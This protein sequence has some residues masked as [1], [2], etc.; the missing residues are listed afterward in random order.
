[1]TRDRWYS[2]GPF[3][4]SGGDYKHITALQIACQQ[5]NTE[6]VQF[7]LKSDGNPNIFR[8]EP[9]YSMNNCLCEASRHG[10]VKMIE[11]LLNI[12]NKFGFKYSFNWDK[13]INIGCN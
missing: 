1:M 5:N 3:G 9:D 2:P 8:T 11:L 4:G 7:L 13:L 10:N 6:M 12:D